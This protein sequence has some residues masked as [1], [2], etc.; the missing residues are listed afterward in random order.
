MFF[1]LTRASLVIGFAVSV[2][3]TFITP[4]SAHDSWISK[5]GLKN[6]AG[7]WCC[8]D[9]DCPVLNYSPRV[10]SSG[11]QLE[12]GEVV[13]FAEVMPSP[14]SSFVR[15]HRPDGTRRC[16]FAPKPAS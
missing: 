11:Y 14:D 10:T 2:A 12:N 5:G 9:Y 4:S 3:G 6:T 13:P 1:R 16:F 7:E 15:C 8:G